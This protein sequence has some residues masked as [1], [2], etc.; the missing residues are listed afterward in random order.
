M[1]TVAIFCSTD[2]I[3]VMSGD[4]TVMCGD[5]TVM[6]GDITVT[7]TPLWSLTVHGCC[8]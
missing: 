6:S 7:V 8:D 3:I 2:D 1:V 5:I 4:I